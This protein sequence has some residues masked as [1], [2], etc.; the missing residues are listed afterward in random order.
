MIPVS[1]HVV[2]GRFMTVSVG[3]CVKIPV[4]TW[5]SRSVVMGFPSM[6]PGVFRPVVIRFI[7][8]PTS[9]A[10][11]ENLKTVCSGVSAEEYVMI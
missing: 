3:G 9:P 8:R 10:A 4:I 5:K 2:R 11:R 6:V 1:S 7:T